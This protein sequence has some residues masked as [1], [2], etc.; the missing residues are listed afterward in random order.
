[1]KSEKG[2][3]RFWQSVKH[4]LRENRSAFIVYSALRILVI[5]IM[6]LQIFNK[7]FQNVFLCLLT[8]ILFI[9]PSVVQ[10]T[11]KVEFPTL[12]EIIILLFIFAA[13]ILG[14]ISAFYIRFPYWDTILHTLNGFLCGAIGFSL[15][16][17]MNGNK[18]LRFELSPLFM[19]VVAFCFSMT[20]GVTWEIFEFSMDTIYHMDMQK[21][22]VIHSIYTVTL[23]P[24]ADNNC[25]GITGIS[26]V[27]VNGSDLGLGGYLDIGLLDTMYDL[28][29][30]VIGAFV[31]SVLGYGFVKYK[32]T[33]SFVNGL[34]PESW[35][36]EKKAGK[37]MENE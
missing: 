12:L 36:E 10:A 16:E 28:I 4:E 1:M 23:D 2:F 21:D 29:V 15:V 31:F 5:G 33:K 6:I 18:K 13:E 19:A 32:D 20:I 35:S 17:I 22:T 11:F 27:A 30:N 7:N 24:L 37:H 14:E 25:V 3:G 26:E 8:L 34:I 9:M